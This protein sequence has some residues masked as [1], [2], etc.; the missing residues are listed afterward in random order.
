MDEAQQHHQEMMARIL[1]EQN[2]QNRLQDGAP[3]TKA[4]LDSALDIQSKDEVAENLKMGIRRMHKFGISLV[5][6]PDLA[7]LPVDEQLAQCGKFASVLLGL[8]PADQ[9]MQIPGV[10]SLARTIM[11]NS[12]PSNPFAK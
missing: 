2:A 4:I 5:H 9:N 11:D 10:A 8:E 3:V 12:F 6:S 7:R 1:A